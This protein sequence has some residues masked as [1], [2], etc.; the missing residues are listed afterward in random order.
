MEFL[1]HQRAAYWA[2]MSG[3]YR[4][5]WQWGATR[6]GKSLA[7][8]C[9][10]T[11]RMIRFPGPYII[12]NTTA[13]NAW[14]VQW[15]MIQAFAA[16]AGVKATDKHGRF[17]HIKVGRSIGYVIGLEKANS[18]RGHMGKTTRGGWYE[19]P[20]LCN[21][22]S[23]DMLLGRAS[24]PDAVNIMAMNPSGPKHWSAGYIQEVAARMGWSQQ[25][26]LEDNTKLRPG[27]R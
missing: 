27:L 2:I 26:R 11:Q 24:L 17:P 13:A 16:R 10:Q 9:G 22:E 21:Q 7:A 4:E 20:H 18:H 19:E 1:A 3:D 6:T 25:T 5:T 23:F 8:G 14:A 12:G 15:P